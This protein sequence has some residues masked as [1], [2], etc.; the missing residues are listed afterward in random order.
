MIMRDGVRSFGNLRIRHGTRN[1]TRVAFLSRLRE[2]RPYFPGLHFVAV[3]VEARVGNQQI[4]NRGN[5]RGN[6]RVAES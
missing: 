1:F 2:P 4:G 5:K 6:S 3:L